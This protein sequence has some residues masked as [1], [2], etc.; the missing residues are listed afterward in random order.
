MDQHPVPRQITTFEF[1]LIGFLTLKQFIY[2]MIFTGIGVA[3][4]Y[5]I[6]IPIVNILLALVSFIFGVILVFIPFNERPL[7]VWIINFL[8]RL[9]SPLQYYYSK[10]ASPP[11]FLSDKHALTNPQ[12]VES[13]ID[14]HQKLEAYTRKSKT[15]ENEEN[16]KKQIEDL[17]R[18]ET[19]FNIT[20]PVAQKDDKPVS[21]HEQQIPE[22]TPYL[23]GEVKNNQNTPLSN[24]LIY[25]KDKAGKSIRILKTN[26]K[27]FFATYQPLTP[28][29]YFFD[30]KDL[31]QKYFFDRMEL[32]VD[33]SNQN[34]INIVS[35]EL[36]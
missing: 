28:D 29:K 13:Y 33:Q 31:G 20:N 35:R 1:K 3:L 18:T 6:P 8:K 14:A 32:S 21:A 2:L 11:K 15:E 26:N 7:D 23:F 19:G 17:I 27:G 16:K 9:S 36:I 5:L 10:N 34:P 22:K 24:I 12:I 4:F 25:I 30:I